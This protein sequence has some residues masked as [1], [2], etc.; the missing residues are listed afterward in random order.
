MKEGE[1]YFL[2]FL[3]SLVLITTFF[4]KNIYVILGTFLVSMYLKRFSKNIKVPEV[5]KRYIKK[6]RN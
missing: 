5:Y 4:T 2:V 3:S 6:L 1:W